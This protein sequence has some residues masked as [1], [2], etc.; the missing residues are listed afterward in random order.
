MVGLTVGWAA[1][2]K[3]ALATEHTRG[4]VLAG[5]RIALLQ[6]EELLARVN[7][8][9]WAEDRFPCEIFRTDWDG[10]RMGADLVDA[11]E[12]AHLLSR[13]RAGK[14][15][16]TEAVFREGRAFLLPHIASAGILDRIA[17]KVA[18]SRPAAM[19]SPLPNRAM[20]LRW[21]SAPAKLPAAGP[22]P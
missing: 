11:I 3:R 19:R 22:P 14:A 18:C 4:G 16:E 1:A 5:R 21:W 10:R 7:R 6:T 9:S 2:P 13:L 8:R 20:R 17:S 12:R 15:A